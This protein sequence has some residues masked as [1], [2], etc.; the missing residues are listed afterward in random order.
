MERTLIVSDTHGKLD[1][2]KTVLAR[3]GHIDRLIHLGDSEGG[4][5]LIQKMVD[6]PCEM[7]AGNCDFGSGLPRN[8]E[9]QV[10]RYKIW[11]T[12]G[13]LYRVNYGPADIMRMAEDYGFDVVMFGHTHEPLIQP[14]AYTPGG[15]MAVNPGSLSQPRQANHRPSFII[16]EL[17]AEGMIHFTLNYL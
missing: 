12:H 14:S 3:I 7:V 6:C 10:G 11:L 4:S 16:M 15:V 9:I 5:A 13:N 1:N 2:L 17:D 8:K